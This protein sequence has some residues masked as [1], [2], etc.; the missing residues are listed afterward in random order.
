MHLFGPGLNLR[1]QTANSDYHDEITT[2]NLIDFI[3]KGGNILVATSSNIAEVIKDFAIEFSVDF[4]DQATKVYDISNSFSGE[5]DSVPVFSSNFGTKAKS[6][7]TAGGVSVKDKISLGP[8]L[9]D[10]VAHRLTRKNSLIVPVLS[11]PPT[12]YSLDLNDEGLIVNPESPFVGSSIVYVSA[13][14]ARNNARVVFSGSALLFSD[15]LSF[16]IFSVYQ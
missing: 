11:G 5:G 10:G 1:T 8:V 7:I 13:L 3:N 14:Q 15:K 6:I 4:D 2:H 12:A 16:Q 9:F